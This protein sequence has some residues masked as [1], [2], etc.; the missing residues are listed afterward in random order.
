MEN[1][2]IWKALSDATRRDILDELRKGRRT[3]GQLVEQFPGL[4]RCA[5]MKHLGILEKSMLI[6]IQREGRYRWNYLNAI[7]LQELHERWVSKYE[8][9]W[10]SGL[11]NLKNTLEHKQ[12]HI[13]ENQTTTIRINVEII[14]N[15]SINKTWKA[16]IYDINS[17]WSKDFYTSSTTREFILEPRVG[18]RMYEDYGNGNGLLWAEVI[19]LKAPNIIEFKGHLTP[20]YGG[21]A[22]T[23]LKLELTEKAGSTI[24]NLLDT[25]MGDVNDKT[26]ADLEAGWKYLYGEG[27]KKYVESI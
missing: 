27:F 19:V 14:I 10:A 23:F 18:G 5:V 8:Q 25:V 20:Q 26:K 24:L 2:F 11:V 7:P 12:S 1:L 4:G 21:P 3:T 15:A 6:T 9:H 13:M 22:I 17:W 16:L